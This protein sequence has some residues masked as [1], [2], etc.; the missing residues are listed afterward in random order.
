MRCSIRRASVGDPKGSHIL[1]QR[2][3]VDLCVVSASR[4]HIHQHHTTA[5]PSQTLPHPAPLSSVQRAWHPHMI[6]RTPSTFVAASIQ[7][8]MAPPSLSHVPFL[9]L[10]RVSHRLPHTPHRSASHA[11]GGLVGALWMRLLR[12]L[13]YHAVCLARGRVVHLVVPLARTDG[14]DGSDCVV[15]FLCVEFVLYSFSAASRG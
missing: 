5:S 12:S 13:S 4:P 3:S 2:R 10:R 11:Q 6:S 14:S 7:P 9:A 15:G 8:S 1:E